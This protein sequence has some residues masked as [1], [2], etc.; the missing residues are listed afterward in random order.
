MIEM[1]VVL[2]LVLMLIPL[3]ALYLLERL[4]AAGKGP[5][6][7]P[8]EMVVLDGTIL[9]VPMPV[10]VPSL[11][12]AVASDDDWK[13]KPPKL[14]DD[15]S[16]AAESRLVAALIS[17]E[18]DRAQYQERMA[19]LAAADSAVHPVRLAPAPPGE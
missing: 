6:A 9:P 17:G 7:N 1:Y 19:D 5:L 11:V 2:A 15:E 16:C 10:P 8:G 18:L 4:A 3:G 12:H 13:R 14:V